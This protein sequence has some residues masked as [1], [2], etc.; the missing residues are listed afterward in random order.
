MIYGTWY[1][2]FWRGGC[3]KTRVKWNLVR[4]PFHCAYLVYY[5]EWVV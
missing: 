1:Q 2:L 3:L 4:L 5:V